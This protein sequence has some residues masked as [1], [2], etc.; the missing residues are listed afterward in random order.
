MEEHGSI[1]LNHITL[2][3]YLESMGSQ[4]EYFFISQ[5]SKETRNK[6]YAK[7]FMEAHG[8]HK[9]IGMVY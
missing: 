2:I 1:K 6:E 4:N 5:D 8:V 3:N 7:L 9:V